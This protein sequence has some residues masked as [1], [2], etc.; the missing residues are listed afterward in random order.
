MF[1]HLPT[2]KSH[3]LKAEL[4]MIFTGAKLLAAKHRASLLPAVRGNELPQVI[5]CRNGVQIALALR[6]PPGEQAVSAQHDPVAG[7]ILLHRA[8]QHHCQ[9]EAGPLPGHPCKVMMK[10]K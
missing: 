6:V 10:L 5:D 8:L 1:T 3:K 4:G 2:E 7:W 9:F